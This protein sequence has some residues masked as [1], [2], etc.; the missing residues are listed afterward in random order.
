MCAFHWYGQW[1]LHNASLCHCLSTQTSYNPA[2]SD[3]ADPDKQQLVCEICTD[4]ASGL[5]YGI[6]SCEG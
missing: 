2:K 4:R 3:K 5:H 1:S 6:I